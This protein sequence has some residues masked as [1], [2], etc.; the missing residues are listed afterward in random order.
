MKQLLHPKPWLLF[1]GLFYIIG[2][3]GAL[4]CETI[5]IIQGIG[6]MIGGTI[7]LLTAALI[8]DPEGL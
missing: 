3:A 8:P 2:S 1:I 5:S 7:M 6:Q 4:D